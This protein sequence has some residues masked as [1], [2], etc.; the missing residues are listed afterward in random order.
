MCCDCRVSLNLCHLP[1]HLLSL[2]VLEQNSDGAMCDLVHGS[3]FACVCAC[4]CVC[5]RVCVL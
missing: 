5:V 3:L 2:R 1:I 4:V